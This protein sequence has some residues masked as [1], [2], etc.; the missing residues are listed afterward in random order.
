MHS[1]PLQALAWLHAC[2]YT[3][4]ALVAAVAPIERGTPMAMIISRSIGI[5]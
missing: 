5:A 2:A 3:R 1:Q 4:A